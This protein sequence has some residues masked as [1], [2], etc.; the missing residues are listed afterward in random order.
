M[1]FA[2]M[3]TVAF[4]WTAG[5]RQTFVG[6]LILMALAADSPLRPSAAAAQQSFFGV[7]VGAASLPRSLEPLC[8]SAR[9]LTAPTATAQGGLQTA[10]ARFATRLEFTVRGYHEEAGCVPRM[11]VSTDSVFK[12]DGTTA[13]TLSA[14]LWLLPAR[15]LS[16]AIGAGWVLGHDSWFLSA[17]VG[18]QYRRI[19]MEFAARWHRTAFEEVRR[20][21]GGQG[22]RELSRADR[23]ERAWGGALRIL[24]VTR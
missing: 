11:G 1:V 5:A 17:G 8:G 15:P 3:M 4:H 10:T 21:F 12:A 14:D 19:R 16:P 22:V 2:F 7:G 24:L 23:V 6:A 20:D 18:G 9:R 13:A